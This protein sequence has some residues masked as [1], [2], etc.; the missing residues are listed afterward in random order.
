MEKKINYENLSYFAYSN[1]KAIKGKIRG[2]VIEFFGL[3]C[4]AMYHNGTDTGAFYAE[5][6]VLYVIPYTN[7]WGWM[8]R[9]EVRLADEVLDV[10]YEKLGLSENIPLISIG[11]SMG[12]LACI[13]YTRYASRTPVGCVANCPVCDLP[14]HFTERVDLPRTLYSAFYS[15]DCTLDEAL[16][17][18]SPLHL[19]KDLP[20]VTEYT[21][22]HC[23]K[24]EAVNLE[25]HSERFVKELSKYKGEVG[26]YVV[27]DRGHCDLDEE[28][29]N[30]YRE[31][32]LS[33]I[34]KHS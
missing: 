16:L 9:D 7:P 14:Y 32:V 34:R 6:N 18:C 30:K 22:F 2:V 5:N 12:G 3:G 1:D 15:Y 29:H 8:N 27:H 19:A 26:Y 10:L 33:Y 20:A 25:M 21:V 24:D 31:V 11:G 17:S 23:D 28:N 4:Q 13:V